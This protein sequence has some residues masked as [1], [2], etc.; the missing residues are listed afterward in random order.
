MGQVNVRGSRSRRNSGGLEKG[1]CRGD[2]RETGL[3]GD[4]HD[5]NRGDNSGDDLGSRC[6]YRDLNLWRG[7]DS[8]SSRWGKNGSGFDKRER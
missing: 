4:G 7:N 3:T 2:S 5:R 8:S 1:E 6:R